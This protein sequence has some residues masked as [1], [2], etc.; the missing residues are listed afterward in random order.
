MAALAS[1][2][3]YFALFLRRSRDT[4]LYLGSIFMSKS[5]SN[6]DFCCDAP[7][8]SASSSFGFSS[9][10]FSKLKWLGP[11]SLAKWSGLSFSFAVLS[12]SSSIYMALKSAYPY[13][14]DYCKFLIWRVLCSIMF[15]NSL[16]SKTFWAW[17][18]ES[19]S[20]SFLCLIFFRFRFSSPTLRA[21]FKFSISFLNPS[22]RI[23]HSSLTL[24]S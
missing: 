16:S 11:P 19:S 8:L 23:S 9:E 7:S 20:L 6:S 4:L 13:V 12:L 5:I 1:L 15:E 21:S 17:R 22:L 14:S 10:D 3:I 18:I 2:R 24:V